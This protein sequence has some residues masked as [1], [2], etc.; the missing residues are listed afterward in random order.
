MEKKLQLTARIIAVQEDMIEKAKDSNNEKR[1]QVVEYEHKIAKTQTQLSQ[2][3][4]DKLIINDQ[5]QK[6][7]K[8][9]KALTSKNKSSS[10]FGF[11]SKSQDQVNEDLVKQR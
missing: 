6:A 2:E 9:L 3:Q 5:I 7:Q 10:W 1:E 4:N 8:K 11:G